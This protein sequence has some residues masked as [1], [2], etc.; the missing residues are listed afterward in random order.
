MALVNGDLQ[1]VEEQVWTRDWLAVQSG[2]Y[3]WDET[4]SGYFDGSGNRL[5][6]E[7]REYLFAPRLNTYQLRA[8]P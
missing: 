8:V 2:D 7:D 5:D 4:R 6:V 1:V 3:S